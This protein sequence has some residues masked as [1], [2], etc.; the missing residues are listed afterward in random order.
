MVKVISL[1]AGGGGSSYGYEYAGAR[2][3]A[4]VEWD[5]QAANNY[6]KNHPKTKVICA[7][8]NHISGEPL[9]KDFGPIDIL[10]GS[11][12][13]QGF[14]SL[15]IK[16]VGSERNDLCF[17]MLR[18]VK[19]LEVPVFVMENVPQFSK[20]QQFRITIKEAERMGF[21]CSAAIIEAASYGAL[22]KR[23]RTFIVGAKKGKFVFPKGSK[24][25]ANAAEEIEKLKEP[26]RHGVISERV[27]LFAGLSGP[28][29]STQMRKVLKRFD[30]E[31]DFS[32][33]SRVPLK[34]V[35]PTQVKSNPLLHHKKNRPLTIEEM[36]L[37]QGFPIDYWAES[38][39]DA[40][41]RIGNSVCPVVTKTICEALIE[42]K[43]VGGTR[44]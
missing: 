24:N 25:T 6:A 42:Q 18:I 37:I 8:V 7:S 31:S 40:T 14:S 29:S 15:N 17:E 35:A 19:E 39:S 23:A 38:H 16:K 11:P 34:G 9:L 43:L 2:V 21:H 41:A 36:A 22:T 5:K 13:C 12:P 3:V 26:M 44:E 32:S 33:M 28:T 4:A 30:K 20:S 10:D 1:F 27:R